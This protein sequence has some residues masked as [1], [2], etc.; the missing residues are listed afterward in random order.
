MQKKF[1]DTVRKS[2]I[3]AL[4]EMQ[5]FQGDSKCE[6]FPSDE[7]IAGWDKWVHVAAKDLC[8]QVHTEVVKN[9]G[10]RSA[11]FTLVL[12]RI[13]VAELLH[14]TIKEIGEYAKATNVTVA[15]INREVLTLLITIESEVRRVPNDQA[16]WTQEVLYCIVEFTKN[17]QYET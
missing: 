3:E 14:C 1:K 12:G 6:K 8:N 7:T 13:N 17:M 16:E 10:H 15:D 4:K 11:A 9:G 5:E 2:D